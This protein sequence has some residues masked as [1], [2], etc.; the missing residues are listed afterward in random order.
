V[1]EAE[2]SRRA[3]GEE[4]VRFL[5]QAATTLIDHCA[6]PANALRVVLMVRSLQ[7]ESLDAAIVFAKASVALGQ[8]EDAIRVLREAAY[9]ARGQRSAIAAIYLEIGKAY[10]AID[11]LL[12]AAEALREAFAADWRT[13]DVALL[14]GLLS[15]DIDDEKTAER[16]LTAVTTLPVHDENPKEASNKSTGLYHLAKMAYARGDFV[17][18]KLLAG[19]A[20]EVSDNADARSL[21][22]RL[23]EAKAASVAG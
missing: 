16:A 13:G 4:K 8:T 7:P 19:K 9:W 10:L 23:M 12:E 14:L 1:L 11:D 18:A 21:L 2:A 15:I 17:K 20:L 22:K 6:D 5:L 3:D